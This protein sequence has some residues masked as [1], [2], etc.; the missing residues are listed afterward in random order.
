MLKN[1]ILSLIIT[2]ATLLLPAISFASTGS[3]ELSPVLSFLQDNLNGI[4]GKII[5]ITATIIALF[6]IAIKFNAYVIAGCVGTALFALYADNFL[7][8]MFGA[9][10]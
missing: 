2:V 6:N 10:I 3:D 4:V 7:I 9:I 5:V 8:A 1:R